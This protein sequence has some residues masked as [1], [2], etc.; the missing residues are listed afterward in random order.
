MKPIIGITIGDF[1]G[2]GPEVA[3]KSVCLTEV[4][5]ICQPILIGS[6]EIFLHYA[7]LFGISAKITSFNNIEDAKNCK[8]IPCV[9]V[10]TGS[11]K[12]LQ[13]GKP[14]PDSGI[15]SGKSIEEAVKFCLNKSIDAFVTSPT[16]KESLHFAGYNF[17]GQTEMIAMLSRSDKVIMILASP[18]MKVGLITVHTPIKEVASLITYQRILDKTELFWNSLQNDFKIKNPKIAMLGLNPHAGENGVL[19]KE[20]IEIIIPAIQKLNLKGINISGPFSSDGFFASNLK[21]NFDGILAMY[22]DQGLIPFK[23]NN[24]EDGVNYSAG[25][26]IIRT[27]P[28]HGT[29]FPIAGKGIADFKSMIS[30][31]KL[32]AN[33]SKNKN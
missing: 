31:I 16:S 32:A 8:N 21:N 28:D 6:A 33:I 24:F 14:S 29:A 7:K 22:H 13:I 3:L 30:A 20:E 10:Y 26:K 5:K 27:S 4:K 23:M 2:I 11:S 9:D 25:L 19:G 17:P 12:Q 1:N 18:K 15:C